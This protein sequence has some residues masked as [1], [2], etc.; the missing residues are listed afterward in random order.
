MDYGFDESYNLLYRTNWVK[1]KN[2]YNYEYWNER[3]GKLTG[4]DYIVLTYGGRVNYAGVTG[5][6]IYNALSNLIL[7]FVSFTPFT[8]SLFGNSGGNI[9]GQLMDGRT[10]PIYDD[11]ELKNGTAKYSAQVLN[12][13]KQYVFETNLNGVYSDDGIRM[14]IATTSDAVYL[15][16]IIEKELERRNA[17]LAKGM[18]PVD[19]AAAKEAYEAEKKRLEEERHQKAVNEVNDLFHSGGKAVAASAAADPYVYFTCTCGQK[20]RFPAGNGEIEFSCPRCK[21]PG[22]M[23]TGR[24][25]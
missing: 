11:A 18:K 7:K 3:Y 8:H 13:L 19:P 25:V 15:K 5:D 2:H 6:T 4:S 22:S 1:S 16:R 23:Y 24:R 14:E 20:M 21:K 10:I 9:Y 12:A 17:Y